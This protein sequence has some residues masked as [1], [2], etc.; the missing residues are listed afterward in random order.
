MYLRWEERLERD[1]RYQLRLL[2]CYVLSCSVFAAMA[3]TVPPSCVP[4]AFQTDK[5]AKLGNEKIAEFLATTEYPTALQEEFIARR[6]AEGALVFIELEIEDE[7]EDGPA[8]GGRMVVRIGEITPYEPPQLTSEI[9]ET[10]PP[11]V[12]VEFELSP[13]FSMVNRSR[14]SSQTSEFGILELYRPIY[15]PKSLYNNIEGIVLMRVLVS[16]SGAVKSIETVTNKTDVH[17]ETAAREALKEWIF[18]P[19]HRDGQAIWFR[20]LVPVQFEIEET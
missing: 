3:L 9:P 18:K 13:D 7:I 19:I 2:R 11:T 20:V 12:D 10:P 17:C 1:D 5:M 16:P 4:A 15:P 6:I 14:E 8:P